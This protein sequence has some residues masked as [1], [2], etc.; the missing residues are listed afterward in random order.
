MS[1]AENDRDIIVA[2]LAAGTGNSFLL[3][4]HGSSEWKESLARLLRG[5]HA[6]I[7]LLRLQYALRYLFSQQKPST[8]FLMYNRHQE[9]PNKSVD[10]VTPSCNTIWSFNSVHWSL[11]A[12]VNVTAEKIRWV[13]SAARYTAAA[14]FELLFG[15]KATATVSFVDH[16]GSKVEYA[17]ERFCLAI[18]NNIRGTSGRAK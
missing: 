5:I 13:G 7:D 14:F 3:E 4:L 2:P 9:K 11:G 17:N 15:S 1:R 10:D 16:T 8:P 18:V 6:P 12:Q